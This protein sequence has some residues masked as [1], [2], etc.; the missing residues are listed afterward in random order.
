MLVLLSA[1]LGLTVGFGLV[2]NRAVARADR[3]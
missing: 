2:A 3:R 1:W